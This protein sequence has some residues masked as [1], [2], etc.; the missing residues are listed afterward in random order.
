LQLAIGDRLE[1]YEILGP[2]G[3]GGMGEVYRARDLKLGRVIALKLLPPELATNVDALRR[4]EQE[5]RA[6]SALNHPN[7]VTIYDI[8]VTENMAWRTADVEECVADRGEARRRPRS[9]A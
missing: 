9:R 5:A 3:A 8:C 7:I 1:Q 2:L 6:A 4:F